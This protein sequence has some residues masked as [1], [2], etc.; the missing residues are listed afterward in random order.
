MHAIQKYAMDLL[1][2]ARQTTLPI[3]E[4][5]VAGELN[6]KVA[7][8]SRARKLLTDIDCWD[9]AKTVKGLSINLSGS[10]YIFYPDDLSAL[11]RRSVIM[12]ECGHIYLRHLG[13]GSILGKN[14]NRR[15]DASQEAEANA[16]AL[17]ALAPPDILARAK[18]NTPGQIARACLISDPDARTVAI[19]MLPSRLRKLLAPVL[20]VAVLLCLYLRPK[21]PSPG[22]AQPSQ[23][24]QPSQPTQA[25]TMVYITKSGDH[26][27]RQDCYQIAGRETIAIDL[28][29]AAEMGYTPCKTC[30]PTQP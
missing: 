16:F 19:H 8:Y 30:R 5:A 14:G 15:R 18:L 2:K 25:T 12:H 3:D 24:P 10:F 17:Y 4:M 20:I 28:D 27:H 26:Y 13:N 9:Y 22:T 23:P 6:A 7:P 11:E 1:A 21:A 29:Q